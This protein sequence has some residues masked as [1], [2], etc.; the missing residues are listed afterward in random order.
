MQL[1]IRRPRRLRQG[2]R[3]AGWLGTRY[4]PGLPADHARFRRRSFISVAFSPG[5]FWT[6]NIR[7]NIDSNS[8]I[9]EHHRKE[10]D[11]F[12]FETTTA[13]LTYEKKNRP[14]NATPTFHFMLQYIFL[15]LTRT[16]LCLFRDTISILPW[17]LTVMIIHPRYSV[18]PSQWAATA[19]CAR[20]ALVGA[21]GERG[22]PQAR[23]ARARRAICMTT[24]VQVGVL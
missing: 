22:S 6:I 21:T 23:R 9:T 4:P 18:P 24:L 16:P 15:C 3:G 10:V 19:M 14:G 20:C 5:S 8:S 11:S 7:I 12:T 13:L 1:P 17:V 2:A